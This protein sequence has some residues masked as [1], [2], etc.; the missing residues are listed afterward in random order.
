MPV[1]AAGRRARCPQCAVTL[2]IPLYEEYDAIL[3][4][5]AAPEDD[6]YDSLDPLPIGDD[7][8]YHFASEPHAV[9]KPSPAPRA[10]VILTKPPEPEPALTC[11]SCQRQLPPGIKFCMACGID[12]K[13]GRSPLMVEDE[14]LDEAYIVGENVIWW[15]SWFVFFGFYPVASE[16]FGT[17]TPWT[18]RVFGLI[19]VL[20]SLWGFE[21]I[22][23]HS[24]PTPLDQ[25]MMLWPNDLTQVR[26][27]WETPESFAEY[28]ESELREQ[29]IGYHHY[30]LI[31]SQFLHGG[32]LHLL[33]NLLFLFIFGSRINAL[34]GNYLTILVYP[35]LGV[36]AALVQLQMNDTLLPYLG[37]S[38]AIAGMSGMYLV[39][40]PT[41]KLHT[42]LWF[43]GG[44][45]ALFFS[46]IFLPCFL[47]LLWLGVMY[48]FK[49]FATIVE[50]RGYWYVLF[51]LAYDALHVYYN[52]Q[53]GVAHW[54]HVGGFLG[55]VA[56]G[57]ILLMSRLINARGGD[58]LSVT[59]GKYA[60]FLIGK[61]TARRL[62]LP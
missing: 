54:A 42:A 45:Y 15:A 12:V 13:T 26:S 4:N 23:Y 41:H 7:D 37:A 24:N 55:G 57:L 34:I 62:S 43:R 2:Q 28:N 47:F 10:S 17:R 36:I 1:S 51:W 8:L 44:L 40:F 61:P 29:G 11:P 53:D 5:D 22:M 18:I 52:A 38:G 21:A 39:L 31:T 46:L 25:N 6:E 60:W 20:F 33:G 35:L 32:P 9:P 27:D 59:L 30:Q 3:I 58:L 56:V 19:C 16:A 49:L 48:I 14:N 50:I